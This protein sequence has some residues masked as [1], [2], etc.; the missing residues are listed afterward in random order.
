MDRGLWY[1]GIPSKAPFVLGNPSQGGFV[2]KRR[3]RLLLRACSEA[4][5]ILPRKLSEIV[6]FLSGS[7]VTNFVRPEKHSGGGNG[8]ALLSLRGT[9]Q[10]RLRIPEESSVST[11]TETVLRQFRGAMSDEAI[12]TIVLALDSPGGTVIGTEELAE[13]IFQARGRKRV[14]S[15]ASHLAASA[16]YWIGAAAGEFYAAPNSHVGSIGVIAVHYDHS[17]ELE[18]S[19]IKPT[20][21][22]SAPLKGAGNP[23]CPP[24][25]EWIEK[26]QQEI[27]G[28]HEKFVGAIARYRGVSRE[29]VESEF[30]R[31]DTL[32][33]EAGVLVGMIDGIKTLDQVFLELRSETKD[34]GKTMDPKIKAAMVLA[35]LIGD[36]ESEGSARATLK[37]FLVAKG[38]TGANPEETIQ[39]LVRSVAASNPGTELQEFAGQL[40]ES[41]NQLVAMVEIAPLNPQAKLELISQFNSK[42][43]AMPEAK[44][45]IQ[46]KIAQENPVAGPSI[47]FVESE[48]DKF[49]LATRN[50]MILKMVGGRAPETIYDP[51]SDSDIK[52]ELKD[53]RS[54]RHLNSLENLGRECLLHA[55]MPQQQ[56]NGLYKTDIAELMLGKPAE[57]VLGFGVSAG[58]YNVSGMYQNILYDAANVV[59]RSGYASNNQTFEIWS[60]RAPDV[61]DFKPIHHVV[62]SEFADPKAIPED[63]EFEEQVFLDGKETYRLT[64]WGFIWSQ[65]LEL[66]LNDSLGETSKFV[67]KAGRS[68]R[69]KQNAIVY[70]EITRNPTLGNDGVALFHTTHK[71]LETGAAVPTTA[72]LDTMR[73]KMRQQT[74]PG[75]ATASMNL[76]PKYLLAPPALEGTVDTLLHSMSNPAS[77]NSG[78]K[79]IWN[80][81]LLPVYDAEMSADFGGSDTAWYLATDPMDMDTVVY[82]YLEGKETPTLDS[83]KFERSLGMGFRFWQAFTAKAIDFYGLQKHAG[84]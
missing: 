55:G 73:K 71:N 67:Q 19:G 5:A 33:A 25:P 80:G 43:I 53:A 26:F 47:R 20:Y 58:A 60:S 44:R 12:E 61:K 41:L 36:E 22:T 63:G 40:G 29:K 21:L 27:N 15:V 76:I 30:G 9:L 48:R 17:A 2:L 16:C 34:G 66:Q 11:A 50:A 75:V 28:L 7:A 24:D 82:A 13:A 37:G 35:G 4:W 56:I 32:Q 79:N 54:I 59:L 65:T 52:F 64:L 6:S 72:T 31:G 18:R 38:L 81:K 1:F 51:R 23:D 10:P 14:I 83:F 74:A 77:N 39:A 57:Q 42:S 3:E 49:H 46:E 78:V 62:G 69:R 84:V 68:F 8:V 45:L 70:N